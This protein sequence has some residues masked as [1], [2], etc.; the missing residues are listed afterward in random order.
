MDHGIVES[1]AESTS[2]LISSPG[3]KVLG[4]FLMTATHAL[5]GGWSPLLLAVVILIVLDFATGFA[6]GAIR[7]CLSSAR[8]VRGLVKIVL[9]MIALIVAHQLR[10]A[11]PGFGEV[12]AGFLTS[13]IVLTESVSILENVGHIAGHYEIQ[14]PWLDVVTTRLRKERDARTERWE[15]G[16]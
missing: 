11:V 12:L 7:H 10:V 4:A 13:Y 1:V 5:L 8:L 6:L 9:Y 14:L 2:K 3:W 15:E 16:E